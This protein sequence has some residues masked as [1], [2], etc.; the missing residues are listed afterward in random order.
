[1]PDFTT[2]ILD[3]TELLAVE[4]L[5]V[6]CTKEHPHRLRD[7]I[8][9]D[10]LRPSVSVEE[11]QRDIELANGCSELNDEHGDNRSSISVHQW[12]T[13]QPSKYS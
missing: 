5:Q 10:V 11:R 9:G 12:Y 2:A 7:E 6:L 13:R 8:P 1:M 3:D 4:E